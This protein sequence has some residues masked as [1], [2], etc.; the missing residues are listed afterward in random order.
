MTSRPEQVPFTYDA[1]YR[2]G[3]Y[4]GVYELPYR[5]SHYYPLFR[6]VLAELRRR[7]ARSVLEVGCGSGAFASMVFE[8]T[9]IDYAGFDFSSVAVEKARARTGRKDAF[10]IGDAT[11]AR[12][13][14]R[15]RPTIVC[16][17]VLEHVEA[18]RRVVEIWAAGTDCI[19]S[20]P[21]FD[22]ST[23]VRHFRSEAE[24]RE[25]YGDLIDIRSIRRVKAPVLTDLSWRSYLRAIR[26][27]RYRP[28]RLLDIAGFSSFD[29]GG[30]FLFT[31]VR[32]SG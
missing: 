22:S 4:E 31:G 13:Y 5:H 19:C 16:T 32:R 20:V 1:M 24:V 25:R 15:P 11:D 26:W 21:N 6:A 27:N 17:E 14:A 30:W 29:S 28:R 3:G 18:D 23:H 9:R 8:K 12:S 7:N 2:S 10:Y